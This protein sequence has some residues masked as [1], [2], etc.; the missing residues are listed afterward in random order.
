[1]NK[2]RNTISAAVMLF[3]FA[4]ITPG[5][6]SGEIKISGS[7]PMLTVVELLAKKGVL[8]VPFGEYL[9]RAVTHLDVNQEQIESAVKVMREIFV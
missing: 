1:M 4:L 3:F 7:E 6:Y 2:L 5:A 8:M 9:V